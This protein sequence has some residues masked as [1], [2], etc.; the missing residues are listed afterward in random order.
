MIALVIL[1]VVLAVATACTSAR[2]GGPT[3]PL[4]PTQS[5]A[6]PSTVTSSTSV[7]PSSTSPGDDPRG[8]AAAA[9]YLAF[10]N[11]SHAAERN[12]ANGNLLNAVRAAAVDPALAVEGEHLFGYRTSGIAWSGQP[13]VSRLTVEKISDGAAPAVTL[14]DCPTLSPSW[15]PYLLSTHKPVP[16]T[17]PP[18]SAKPPH[19][20]TARVIY[21]KSRWMVQS[22]TTEVK[23]TCTPS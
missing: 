16:V 22:T 21:Y 12:P 5:S 3:P 17:F 9:A 11:A 23:A 14:V 6:T 19:A 1:P 18:G 4:S 10:I 20:T 15:Q 7:T 2:R 13:P 8:K